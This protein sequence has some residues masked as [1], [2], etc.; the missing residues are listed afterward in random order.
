MHDTPEAASF[1]GGKVTELLSSVSGVVVS[2]PASAKPVLTFQNFALR[3]DKS[4]LAASFHQP[5]DWALPSGKRIAVIT[6]NSFLRYQLVVALAGLVPP[7]SGEIFGDCVIGWPVGGEG[8][9]DSKLRISHALNF[10][11]TVYGDCLECSQVS[12]DQIW[13]LLFEVNIYPHLVIKELSKNQKDFFFLA[14]SV[15]FS[16][17]LYLIPKTKYLMSSAA[18]PLR[19]LLLQQVEGKTVIATS[20]NNR[21]MRAF[22]TDGLVL[23][24]SGE[25]LF[26][27]GLSESMQWAEC[28]VEVDVVSNS[29]VDQFDV[30]L[31]LSNS[32]IMDDSN[33]F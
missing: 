23:G 27:G 4:D 10:L 16:F 9:L 17:D 33:D 8:G 24:G 28:N 3:C 30:G 2:T 21:F 26:A 19:R 1:H 14:L 6:R 25:I 18:K 13:E 22:C 7:V 15:L 11:S 12:L 5:W 20:T 32:E 29:E 31:N